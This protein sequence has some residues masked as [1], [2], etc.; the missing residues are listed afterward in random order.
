MIVGIKDN[1]MIIQAS[2]GDKFAVKLDRCIVDIPA[3]DGTGKMKCGWFD[4]RELLMKNHINPRTTAD[5]AGAALRVCG[6]WLDC[7][8]KALAIRTIKKYLDSK[9]EE[10]RDETVA[11]MTSLYG[12]DIA[13][14]LSKGVRELAFH[15]PCY[16]LKESGFSKIVLGLLNDWRGCASASY[17]PPRTVSGA[18]QVC[19]M[20]GGSKCRV[21]MRDILRNTKLDEKR[22]PAVFE[23]VK[24]LETTR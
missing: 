15:F 10:R 20:T 6:G 18:L 4:M 2:N 21:W 8:E 11:L 23:T 3:R 1:N 24:Y 7:P 5:E 12:L 14:K 22:I 17:Y 19:Q 9:R 13:L 16:Y